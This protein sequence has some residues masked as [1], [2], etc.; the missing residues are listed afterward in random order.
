MSRSPQHRRSAPDAAHVSKRTPPL[1]T[2]PQLLKI[3]VESRGTESATVHCM[4][5]MRHLIAPLLVLTACT[6]GGDT[7]PD[8]VPKQPPIW[9]DAPT[10][11]VLVGEGQTVA[12]PLTASDPDGGEVTVSATIGVGIDA[13]AVCEELRV[14]AGYGAAPGPITVTIT[15]DEG[16]TVAIELAVQVAPIGWVDYQTWTTAQGPEEREHAT[17]LFHEESGQAYMFGGSGYHP[18]FTQMMDDFW[19]YDTASGV[20]TEIT[21]TGDIP[22]AGGSQR[23]AGTWG[24]GE[25]IIFGGY[26]ADGVDSNALHRVTVENDTLR[27]ELIESVDPKPAPRSLHG[28]VYDGVTDRYFAFGGIGSVPTDDTWMMQVVDGTAQWAGLDMP[29]GSPTP[30]YGF[31]YGFDDDAGRMILFS[32]AQGTAQLNPAG[33]TWALDTRAEP[34]LWVQLTGQGPEGRRNGCAVWDPTGPRL[35]VFGGTPDA[36]TTAPGLHLF[37]ARPGLESWTT[38]PLDNEPQVRSSG[39]GFADGQRVYVGFGNDNAVYRDW[40]ILGY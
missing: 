37:D 17:V 28:F 2:T 12:L 27:F 5:R 3:N 15:D 19:R 23:F 9:Q 35:V 33:D 40:G 36:M 10:A 14:H 7:E 13:S 31:F 22:P 39:F 24:S 20:W 16:D 25:G 18:Q 30:R 1:S 26:F 21:P 11:P 38:L 32:G 29:N 4:M 6:T 34:P 8:D